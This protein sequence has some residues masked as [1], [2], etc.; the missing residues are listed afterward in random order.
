VS[1]RRERTT[2]A[3][4]LAPPRGADD[5]GSLIRVGVGLL[6]ALAAVGA[7][8]SVTA[9]A[10]REASLVIRPGRSIG[11]FALG[12]TEQEVRRVAG[13]PAYVV[14]QGRA[15]LGQRRVEWQYGAAAQYIV[16]LV[17]RPGRMRVTFVSTTL[18]RERT[19]QG[20]GT[21]SRERALRDAYPEIRCG[22]LNPPP[23]PGAPADTNP[24]AANGR[25]FTLFSA[26]GTR[27]I[28]RTQVTDTRYGVTV[29]EYL[30]RAV[31]VEVVV[32]VSACRRWRPTC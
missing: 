11:K 32:S 1:S 29:E 19:P 7:T 27:T 22:S 25:D 26:R 31:V 5:V 14:A 28:F 23:P 21:G 17:G 13:R 10:A 3:A 20:I 8:A 6:L 16:R 4:R 30:R 18:R 24:Y 9:D 12:M 15:S 2:A